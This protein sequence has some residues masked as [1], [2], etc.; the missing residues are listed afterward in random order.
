MKKI[1]KQYLSF[2]GKD[3]KVWRIDYSNIDID[4]EEILM[5]FDEQYCNGEYVI[6]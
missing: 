3:L 6:K 5:N 1:V 2:K 4:L